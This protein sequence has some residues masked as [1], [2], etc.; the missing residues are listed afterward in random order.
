MK[1]IKAIKQIPCFVGFDMKE[2]EG[3]EVGEH[4]EYPSRV[5]D[6]LVKRNLGVILN[7]KI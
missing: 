6:L 5:A 1:I 2:Y 7:E 3:L 4:R